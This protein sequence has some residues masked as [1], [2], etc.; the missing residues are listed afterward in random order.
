[1]TQV[2]TVEKLLQGGKAEVTVTRQSACSHDC[3]SC[4]GCGAGGRVIRAVAVD[5]IGVQEGDQ[6]ILYSRDGSVLG[7][8]AAVYLLPLLFFLVGYSLSVR[9]ESLPLKVL[10]VL[11]FTALGV[12][13]ALLLDR[14]GHGTRFE[15]REKL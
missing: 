4:P 12:L 3:A 9:A 15:I 1:M 6:V 8:A 13:P 10:V 2:A 11:A 7:A 5:C 14:L